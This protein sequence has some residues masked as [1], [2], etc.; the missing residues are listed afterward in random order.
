[1]Q[2]YTSTCRIEAFVTKCTLQNL[3][4][5]EVDR[6]ESYATKVIHL[7]LLQNDTGFTNEQAI[8]K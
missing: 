2:L 6:N 8:V 4:T 5:P 3:F 7:T 1:M